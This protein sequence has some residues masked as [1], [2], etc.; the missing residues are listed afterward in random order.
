[1]IDVE[2]DPRRPVKRKLKQLKV[3]HSGDTVEK[4]VRVGAMA[5]GTDLIEHFTYAH[6]LVQQ[7]V[8]PQLFSSNVMFAREDSFVVSAKVRST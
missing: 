3:P 8:E 4:H 7:I 5:L 6:N 1:M 2:Q